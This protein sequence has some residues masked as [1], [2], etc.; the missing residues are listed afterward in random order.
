MPR[1]ILLRGPTAWRGV[2]LDEHGWSL[3][4]ARTGWQS[5]QLRRDSLALPAAVILR[6]RLPGRRLSHGLCI[7]RDALTGEQHRRLRVRLKFSR[8]RWAEAESY[9][10]Q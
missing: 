5:I 1:S 10:P 7:P 2:R 9:R 8:N 4:S 6:F 3:W